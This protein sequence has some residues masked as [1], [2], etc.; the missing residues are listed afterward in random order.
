MYGSGFAAADV[1]ALNPLTEPILAIFCVHF[2]VTEGNLLEFQY[3]P[4]LNG[5]DLEGIEF[6]AVASGQHRVDE[7]FLFFKKGPLFGLSCF[8]KREAGE[9]ERHARMRSVGI[10]MGHFAPLAVHYDFLY[11]AVR[12]VNTVQ[13]FEFLVE[14][15][16]EHQSRHMS[17]TRLPT[18]I[19]N[20]ALVC[21]HSTSPVH[22][23]AINR[24][25]EVYRENAL[26][27]W[28]AMLL[29]KRVLFLT[30]APVSVACEA[31]YAA[32]HLIM[33]RS[34]NIL[35]LFDSFFSPLFYVQVEDIDEL[36][37]MSSFVACTSEAIMADRHDLYDILIMPDNQIRVRKELSALLGLNRGDLARF[38]LLRE[39]ISTQTDRRAIENTIVKYFR[40]MTEELFRRLQYFADEGTTLT[41]S[42]AHIFGIKSFDG[43]FLQAITR[44]YNIPVKWRS[45]CAGCCG[46]C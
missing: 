4:D 17:R 45:S 29:Q 22:T 20:K 38:E 24:F 18:G 23:N 25:I 9:E 7:D 15:F 13:N 26:L 39:R 41:P 1:A 33:S 19:S 2:H 43:A 35:S 34:S 27:V 30:T 14:Y 12:R 40:L 37:L 28:K 44:M 6:K 8:Q 21:F 46:L 32:A 16:V 3:P 5:V 42:S 11:E 36:R 10:L 31:V